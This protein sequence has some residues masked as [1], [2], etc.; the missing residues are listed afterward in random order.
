MSETISVAT[1]DGILSRVRYRPAGFNPVEARIAAAV[2]EDPTRVARESIVSFARRLSV[3]TGSIVRFAKLLGLTG[4]YDLKLAIAAET[5]LERNAVQEQ[6]GV[7][8]FRA[9]MD[10][11]IRAI[12]LAIE[13]IDP[14][15]IDEAA[16]V[17]TRARRVDIAATGASIAMAQSLLF[18]LTLMGLH[19]RLLGDASEQGAAAA[20]LGEGDCLI[21][22]SVSGRT[23]PIV[24][25]ASRAA[26]AGATVIAMTCNARSPI[27]KQ[28]TIQLV[29][30]AQKG[31][32]DA[33]WP[34]RTALGA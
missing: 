30:D 33:E 34:L 15:S 26:D 20:F 12:A 1:Q 13:E 32:F 22:I 6:A 29:V 16:F 19:V 7:S 4:Y 31:K 9:S 18:S 14:T 23:R 21:A 10:E 25:A 28:A 3:S 5:A 11:Q 27:L 24:D 17:L 2:L 8:R